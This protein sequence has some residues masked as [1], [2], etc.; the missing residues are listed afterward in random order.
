[1]RL[2]KS[3]IVIIVL[4]LVAAVMAIFLL[5]SSKKRIDFNS[6]VKP[7]FNKK[8]ISCHGG[9]KQQSGF[10]L[11]FREE[12][13]QKAKSGK[14]AIVPGSAA[15]SELIR[16]IQVNDVEERMPYKHN[17]LS[18][19]EVKIL[20]QWINEGAE[21]G[22]HWA[23]VPVRQPVVPNLKDIWIKNDIDRF[24]IQKLQSE[25]LLPS[26][27]ADKATLL[28][29]VS[30]DLTGLPPTESVAQ[31]FLKDS[32]A[33]AYENLVDGLLASPAYGERWTSLWLDLAR[34]GDTKG[35][36]SDQPRTIWRYRDWLIKAFNDDKPYDVFLTEQLAGDL[37][38]GAT[39][40]HYIATA[41]HRNTM[42]NDEGG[43]D[44]E[45]FRTAAVMDRVNTTWTALMGTTFN[46]VQ[47]HSHPYD[48][49][50]HE[51]YYKFLAFFNNTRDEDTEQDYPL[52]RFYSGKD[53]TACLEF[54]QWLKA[55]A[56][57]EEEKWYSDFL[58]TA[59][60]SVNSLRC[61]EYTRGLL[62]QKN[63]ASLDIGG[64][65]RLPGIT[66]EGKKQMMFRYLNNKGTAVLNIY[67]D[68]LKGRLLLKVPLMDCKGNWTVTMLDLPELNGKHDLWF[69]FNCPAERDPLPLLFDWFAFS[70]AF[71]GVGKPG[72]AD[73][74]RDF[75]RLLMTQPE[76]MPVMI[77]NN[78]E[79]RRASHIF[80]RGNWL[81]KGKDVIPGVPHSMNA[82]PKDA[83]ANR[84]GLAQWLVD[85]NNPLTART[86]ANRLWEQLFGA[87]LT[88]TLEDMG[89]QGQPPIHRELLDYLAWQF[90]HTHNWSMKQILKQLVMSSTYRQSSK[91][92][93]QQM[94]RDPNNTLLARFSRIRLSSE[95]LRDQALSVSGLL[96]NKMYGKSVMPYQPE[97]VWLS[98]YNPLK[99]QLSTGEDQYRRAVYTYVKRTA[100][101]PSAI[102]FDGGSREVCMPRRIR[103]NT[104]LQALNSLNDSAYLVLSRQ[105]AV[106]L[107]QD[108]MD[109]KSQI[110]KAY[111]SMFFKTIDDARLKILMQLYDKALGLYENDRVAAAAMMGVKEKEVRPETAALSVVT[112]ALFNLDEW[113]DKN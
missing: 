42:T 21:W 12:A 28:R 108:G 27:Q 30:L 57:A 49:F 78:N 107:Q 54:K 69:Q 81:V 33:S 99:W 25:K 8:C 88:E 59:Q 31:Q 52:L 18:N 68:S 35:F 55:N 46:C 51:E 53:S 11:L 2:L 77:E 58:S 74:K 40:A 44:N 65:C 50:K 100:P 17:P 29:R 102:N 16:R 32:S 7:I 76:T 82:M 84:L 73:A 26:P 75:L 89:T 110:G 34:Y 95:Q 93:P 36:E 97:G 72:Q 38:P 104:P 63:Y 96:S 10:S 43:T 105:F 66:T 48:P 20:K 4:L 47:C 9:V 19:E 67:A 24:V 61:D 85:K 1:M 64:T 112:N 5:S 15:K 14:Y 101:Y 111:Q 22:T 3:K 87:G 45:E 83:P 86:M 62:Y 37:M 41:F 13:L 71:P 113:V 109:V 94:Q 39:E 6:Q 79:Q 98:P 80:E 91:T 60:P 92:T 103:T 106:S 56:D 23:Y 70:K 90:M